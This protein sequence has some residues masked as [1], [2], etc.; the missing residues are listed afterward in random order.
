MRIPNNLHSFDFQAFSLT[1]TFTGIR[2]PVEFWFLQENNLFLAENKPSS[3][4]FILFIAQ[5]TDFISLLMNFP[6]CFANECSQRGMWNT[7]NQ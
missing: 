5:W 3:I 7:Q 1:N 4:F 2:F 6:K